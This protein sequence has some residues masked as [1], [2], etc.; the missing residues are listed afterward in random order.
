MESRTKNSSRNAMVGLINKL[1]ILL[2]NFIGRKIFINYI[3]IEYLGINGLFSNILSLLSLADLGFGTAMNYSFYKPLAENDEKRIAAL[4]NFYKKVYNF[5]AIAVLILGLLFIPLL[6]YIINTDREIEHITLYYLVFLANSVSSYLMVYKSS[7]INADQKGYIVNK[8]L[9]IVHIVKTVVQILC[10]LVLRNY[11]LYI[12]IDVFATLFNN[13]IVSHKAKKLYPFITKSN[14]CISKKESKIIFENLKSVF[15]YKISGTLLNSVDSI[16]ISSLLGIAIVG[17]Y[18][19]YQMIINNINQIITIIFGSVTASIGNLIITGDTKDRLKVFKSLQLVSFWFSGF[20]TVCTYNLSAS[21]IY[22]WLGEEFV[23]NN[24]VTLAIA[25][26]VF[27]STSM[28]PL[29][30]YREATGLYKKTKYIM[31]LAALINLILSFILGK[32]IGLAGIIFATILSRILTYFWYEPR[33]LFREYFNASELKYYLSY[34]RNIVIIIICMIICSKITYY[35]PI[36]GW[37]GWLLNACII[38]FVVNVI[39]LILNINTEEFS[40]LVLRIKSM[41]KNN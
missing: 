20:L 19:N 5:I 31:L 40:Y 6:P 21:F 28:Q 37:I 13:L 18:N 41:I 32:I 15:V 33:L 34:V 26:N 29:W 4:I 10:A 16:L 38:T 24:L 30:S 9:I 1:I 3:G 8:I 7:I 25:F 27:F 2:L 12:L 36:R 22:N 14:E 17:Y 23:L 39:Y 35:N 11:L